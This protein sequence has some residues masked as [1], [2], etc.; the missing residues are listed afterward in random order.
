MKCK[1]LHESRGRMRIRFCQCN[2]TIAQ[3]SAFLG[4]AQ[5]RYAAVSIRPFQSDNAAVQ[6]VRIDQKEHR[7]RC[8]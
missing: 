6:S 5:I 3:A 8:R 2:I 4:K 7:A 1:I